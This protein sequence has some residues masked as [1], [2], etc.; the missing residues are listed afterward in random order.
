M[1]KLSYYSVIG[2]RARAKWKA[3]SEWGA[4]ARVRGQNQLFAMWIVAREKP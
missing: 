2:M 4:G 1:R 3:Q